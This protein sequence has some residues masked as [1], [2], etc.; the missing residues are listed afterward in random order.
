MKDNVWRMM[1]SCWRLFVKRREHLY[2]MITLGLMGL[3]ISAIWTASTVQARPIP[4]TR[5]PSQA[6]TI[7]V[8]H[9][10]VGEREAFLH[11]LISEFE[12]AYPT[13]TV[14]AESHYPSIELYNQ[15]MDAIKSGGETPNVL[16]GYPNQMWSLA[17]FDALRFLDDLAEDPIVGLDATDFYTPALEENRLPE[18]DGQLAGLPINHRATT[19]LFY[20][21]DLLTTA[22]ITV[23]QTWDEF[24]TDCVSLTTGT[25]SGTIL[26]TNFTEFINLLWTR[27]GEPYSQD[28]KRARFNDAY[29]I[30]SLRLF[31]DLLDGGYAR[32][33]R[34]A[35]EDQAV[36]AEGQ[37]VFVIGSSTTIPYIRAAI[38]E[39][40]V[41]NRWGIALLPAVPGHKT[42]M[43]VGNDIAILRATAA[44]ERASWLF[45]R[46]F[47]E[48]DQ[49][50][51]F[52]A[53][54]GDYPVRISASTH[55]S[56]TEKLGSDPQYAEALEL[57]GEYGRNQTVL[58][59]LTGIYTEMKAAVDAVLYDNQPITPTLDAAAAN[60]DS[61][62]ALTGPDAATITPWGGQLVYT[63]TQG[64][65]STTTF[66]P[67]ALDV[68]TTVAY[69]PLND[70]PSD[71][72]SFALVPNMVL[73]RPVTVTIFYRDEDVVGMDE[74]ELKL[75]NYDWQ[76]NEWVDANPCGG[77]IRDPL[78]NKLTS[79]V[80]HFSDHAL[81]D[82][83]VNRVYL[84]LVS[85]LAGP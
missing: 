79:I 68:T 24:Y 81:M 4:I 15:V 61:I 40:G 64:L 65:T 85:K 70:L 60:V 54:L 6:T 13:I 27:G 17:R 21:G 19:M 56:M 66:P 63:N 44:E 32:M 82:R 52:A 84:P 74:N 25:I 34:F 18:Y 50:A 23:P 53:K 51:R 78:N 69:V 30:D 49:N 76:N 5:F 39:A 36:F 11:E 67:G 38:E 33:E 28:L 7:T 26:R 10:Y 62:L 35:Y 83:P 3:A 55:P 22:G 29:G 9:A 31:R 1:T 80:C 77:Y 46:W 48:R 37:A 42:V 57:L 12:S 16:F 2:L 59:G 47:T 14:Q 41:V 45:L 8:W 75:F 71:G 72:L 20:N 73:S 43:D 58:L